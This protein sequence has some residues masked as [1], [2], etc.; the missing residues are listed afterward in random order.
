VELYEVYYNQT[1]DVQE[2]IYYFN[3]PESAVLTG[4]WLGDSPDRRALGY[5]VARAAAQGLPQRGPAQRRSGP[6]EQIGRASTACAFRSSGQISMERGQDKADFETP[7]ALLMDDLP[8]PAVDGLA[9]AAPGFKTMFLGWRYAA[10]GQWQ[11]W[12]KFEMWM[13]E[14]CPSPPRQPAAHRVD[15]PGG[16]S[17]LAQPAAQVQLPGLPAGAWRSCSTA[18]TACKRTPPGGEA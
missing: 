7:A 1:G 12:R 10:S 4:L 17:V 9:A 5:Q 18:R 6:A 14:R 11:P 8:D 16:Q 3:L 2:V 13:P 15:F